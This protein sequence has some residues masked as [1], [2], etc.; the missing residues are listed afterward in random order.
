MRS[1]PFFGFGA[2]HNPTKLPTTSAVD[3]TAAQATADLAY[4]GDNKCRLNVCPQNK[5]CMVDSRGL[6]FALFETKEESTFATFSA[7]EVTKPFDEEKTYYN[8]LTEE[9]KKNS[10]RLKK[11]KSL[12]T[13]THYDRYLNLDKWVN[14]FGE[15]NQNEKYQKADVDNP[16]S[17]SETKELRKDGMRHSV[18]QSVSKKWFVWKKCKGDSEDSGN[19]NKLDKENA[20]H[21]LFKMVKKDDPNSTADPPAQIEVPGTVE[22][23][24]NRQTKYCQSRLQEGKDGLAPLYY[25]VKPQRDDVLEENGQSKTSKN[26]CPELSKNANTDDRE[27]YYPAEGSGSSKP[28]LQKYQSWSSELNWRGLYYGE[29]HK[30]FSLLGEGE[31]FV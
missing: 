10:E 24:Y 19:A 5:I 6:L 9:A 20:C 27:W 3:I 28:T 16:P 4:D 18:V 12:L 21:K 14:K 25:I 13:K 2:N 23:F 8:M 17:L 29:E 30:I 11:N 31:R 15:K 1:Q 7:T 22:L 26:Y